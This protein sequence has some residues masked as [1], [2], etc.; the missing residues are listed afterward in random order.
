MMTEHLRK[1]MEQL[2][3]Q[4]EDVQEKYAAEIELDL[5]E[6]ARSATQLA[7]PKETDLDYLLAE[8]KEQVARGETYDLDELLDT[9]D[10][11][12]DTGSAITRS[13][14]LLSRVAEH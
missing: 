7:D 1:V 2:A 8:A 4:P 13:M 11:D 12:T 3:E 9:L 14:M 6:Q 5:E 10:D